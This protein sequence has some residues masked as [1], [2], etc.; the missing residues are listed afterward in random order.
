MTDR[1]K[2]QNLVYI[3]Q[4]EDEKKKKKM[5]LTGTKKICNNN[6]RTGLKN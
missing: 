1:C 6:T 5:L 4:I 2:G 3:H